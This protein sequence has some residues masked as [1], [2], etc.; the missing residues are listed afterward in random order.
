MLPRQEPSS[1][2]VALAGQGR[3]AALPL[4]RR[5]RDL[6]R[7]TA[8]LHRTTTPKRLSFS[9]CPFHLHFHRNNLLS[10]LQSC[11]SL[12]YSRSV[13]S[14]WLLRLS[15]CLRSP[16]YL[17]PITPTMLFQRSSTTTPKSSMSTVQP[18]HTPLKVTA[19]AS[20]SGLLMLRAISK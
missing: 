3:F 16:I 9:F 19:M 12:H 13:R 8:P 5:F 1:I 10:T 20:M 6:L 4:C 18:A 11:C 17:T 15:C 7:N 2:P 14:E